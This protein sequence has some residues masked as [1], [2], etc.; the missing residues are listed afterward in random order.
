MLAAVE[1]LVQTLFK[2][3]ARTQPEYR[4]QFAALERLYK[5]QRRILGQMNDDVR[6]QRREEF[7]K[8]LSYNLMG[9]M[10][11]IVRIEFVAAYGL[12]FT[13]KYRLVMVHHHQRYELLID[14]RYG[15]TASICLLSDRIQC[16]Q[17]FFFHT[18][19]G[20]H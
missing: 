1:E 5:C 13:Q 7:Q 3:P 19:E 17:C 8:E 18:T 15:D 10:A 9:N 14:L 4:R 16:F 11:P 6:P 20:A 2:M 12:D